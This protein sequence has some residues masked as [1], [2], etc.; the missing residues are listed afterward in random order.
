M[1]KERIVG[2]P[3]KDWFTAFWVNRNAKRKRPADVLWAWKLFLDKTENRDAVL[4]MHTDPYDQEGPNLVAVAEH[5]QIMDNVVFS[6]DRI[7]FDKMN[8]L[9][10][11]Y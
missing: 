8:I 1:W 2:F 5:F 6:T 3:R 9:Q 4:V 10:R 11:F 7:D